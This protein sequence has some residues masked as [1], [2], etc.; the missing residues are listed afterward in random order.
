MDAARRV[1]FE[2]K[3]VFSSVS[4]VL[5]SLKKKKNEPINKQNVKIVLT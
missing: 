1:R 5:Q 4:D 2:V 3:F